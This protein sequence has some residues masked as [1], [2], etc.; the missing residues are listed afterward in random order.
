MDETEQKKREGETQIT[1][2]ESK[3][4]KKYEPIIDKLNIEIKELKVMTE[5]TYLICK[6]RK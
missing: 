4:K 3:A 2:E 5:E 1:V 6:G